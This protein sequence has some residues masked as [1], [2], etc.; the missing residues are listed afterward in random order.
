MILPK[1]YFSKDRNKA[2]LKNLCSL[3]DLNG[4]CN[5]T[6][7]TNFYIPISSKNF[8]KLVVGSSLA[9]K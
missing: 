5:L 6:G 2:E 7:L 1:K 4:L 3:I 8:L 9:P